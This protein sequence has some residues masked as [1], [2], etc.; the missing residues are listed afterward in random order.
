M[1]DARTLGRYLL[2]QLPGWTVA[3]LLA[4]V[5]VEWRLV[6]PPVAWGCVALWLAKDAVLYRFVRR[7][8]D[9]SGPTHG[10]VGENGVAEGAIDPEGWVRIGPERW[11]ARLAPGADAIAPHAAVRVIAV[12]GLVLRVAP[13]QSAVE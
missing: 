2:F 10:H 3:A 11:R 13:E 1:S 6:S 8:Y 12:D 9:A 5:A 7:A 4:I